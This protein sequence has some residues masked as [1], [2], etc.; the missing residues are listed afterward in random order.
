VPQP[1]DG[2]VV[3]N[4]TVIG[5]HD[6]ATAIC[7]HRPALHCGIRGERDDIRATDVANSADR[8]P[9]IC[10]CDESEFAIVEKGAESH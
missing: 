5:S 3:S 4:G 9:V 2:R 7:A 1:N 6:G 8:T 10:G